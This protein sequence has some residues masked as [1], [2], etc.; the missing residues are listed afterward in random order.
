[1]NIYKVC[2]DLVG[3]MKSRRKRTVEWGMF[4]LY[5]YGQSPGYFCVTAREG[6]GCWM[7]SEEPLTPEVF[8]Y[9]WTRKKAGLRERPRGDTFPCLR[10]SKRKKEKSSR[11]VSVAARVA[12]ETLCKDEKKRKH[13]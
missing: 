3:R 1:M 2:M 6:S 12:Q 11:M 13:V 7:P 4:L 10:H 8:M 5:V 9:R